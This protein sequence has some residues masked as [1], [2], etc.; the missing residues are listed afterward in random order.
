MKKICFFYLFTSIIICVAF[1]STCKKEVSVIETAPVLRLVQLCDPQLGIPN[2]SYELAVSNLERAV[3]LVNEI[4]PDALLVCGDMVQYHENDEYINKFLEVIARVKAPVLLNP[5]NHDMPEPPTI[6]GLQR[7]RSFFGDDFQTMNCKGY[8]IISANSLLFWPNMGPPEEN[9]R[10]RERLNNALQTAQNKKQPIVMVTHYAP[11]YGEPGNEVFGLPKYMVDLFNEK[12][13]FIW[14]AGHW[15]LAD[16]RVY[17]NITILAGEATCANSDGTPPGFRLI[18][19]Y[20][21]NSFDWDY[22]LLY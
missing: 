13:V 2:I 5:G 17:K 16:R 6:E 18:T 9:Q 10:H 4:A 14:L 22:V 3:Q 11:I 8:A 15:H 19:I 7:Y 12:G 1:F 20:P 21:D